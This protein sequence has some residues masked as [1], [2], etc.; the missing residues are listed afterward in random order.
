MAIT[1]CLNNILTN[2]IIKQKLRK[3]NPKT[4]ERTGLIAKSS[5]IWFLF[6][7]IRTYSF[8]MINFV[9]RLFFF[10]DAFN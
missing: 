9:K 6:I 8:S 2:L 3:R 7:E 5:N 10:W 1:I 4:W